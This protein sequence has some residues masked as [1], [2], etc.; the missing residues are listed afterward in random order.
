LEKLRWKDFDVLKL[1]DKIVGSLI[2][3]PSA[4]S[5]IGEFLTVDLPPKMGFSPSECQVVLGN[6]EETVLTLEFSMCN[7]LYR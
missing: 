7:Y 1:L 2:D 4:I 3:N 6:V 5:K